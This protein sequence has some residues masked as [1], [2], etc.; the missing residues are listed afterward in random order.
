MSNLSLLDYLK[1]ME[2]EDRESFAA[3]CGTT[4]G[5]LN[6][7]AYGYKTCAEALAMAVE[8]E[9]AGK[10]RVETLCPDAD[11]AVVR[12]TAKPKA[13]RAAA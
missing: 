13:R 9:S 2:K 12:G 10:V 5:H 6:N 11:W 3:S 7:V 1:T 8:R 4:L